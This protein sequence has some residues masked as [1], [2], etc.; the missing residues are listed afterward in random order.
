MVG[1]F[2]VAEILF[3]VGPT[4]HATSITICTPIK[5][6]SRFV[7]FQPKGMYRVCLPEAHLAAAAAH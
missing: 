3:P 4:V 7:E 6:V 2:S 5:K 1:L